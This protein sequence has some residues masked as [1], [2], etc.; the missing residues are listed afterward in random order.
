MEFFFSEDP[1]QDWPWRWQEMIAQLDDASMRHVVEGDDPSN[2]SR[3]VTGCMLWKTDVYD[4]QRHYMLKEA[5]K[6]AKKAAEE[7]AAAAA[8]VA[9]PPPPPPAPPAT[10]RNPLQSSEDMLMVWDFVVFRANGTL[11]SLHPNYSN[12][13]I[14]CK[15]GLQAH[16][17]P[18]PASSQ[19]IPRTGKGGTSGPGTYKR[20]KFR[21][22]DKVLR[23]DGR[24]HP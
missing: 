3:G 4:H 22:C 13:K 7:A 14:R 24:K 12:V 17:G 20:F 18:G 2:R 9:D 23:F 21:N 6:K 19:E 11:I 8:A 16:L 10:A 5:E 1:T 15:E